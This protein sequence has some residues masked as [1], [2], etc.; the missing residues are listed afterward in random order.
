MPLRLIDSHAHLTDDRFADDVEAVIDR[1]V[2]AGVSRIVTVAT[3]P[4]DAAAAIALAERFPQLAATAGVHPHASGAVPASDESLN[5]LRNLAHHPRVVAIGE[6]GLDYHY[7]FSPR[8]RQVE[9]FRLQL[10]LAAETGLPIVVHAREADDDIIKMIREADPAC[11]GVLHCFS[12]GQRLLET[13][14]E[15]GWMISFAGMVTFKRYEA[16]DLVR[17]VPLDR[18][19]VETDSPYLA[20]VPRRGKRNEPA[21]VIHTAQRIAELRGDDPVELARATSA[22]AR[23]FFRLQ[24]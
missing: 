21:F 4:D 20:P 17:S 15:L 22:N 6:A 3:D 5:R 9:W 7:D 18:L 24:D 13:G 1:A 14:L 10:E 8:D 12:S 23:E 11:R 19:L 2:K 16:A